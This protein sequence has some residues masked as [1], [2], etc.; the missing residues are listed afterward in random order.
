M[1]FSHSLLVAMSN[2][3]LYLKGLPWGITVPQLY[4]FVG[5]HVAE[6]PVAVYVHRND[7]MRKKCSAFVTFA[8]DVTHLVGQLNGKVYKTYWISCEVAAAKRQRFLG[9]ASL[10]CSLVFLSSV[11]AP[12]TVLLWYRNLLA[13]C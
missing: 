1:S 5:E 8:G 12:H 7:P 2:N 3:R 9:S 4:G 10:P 13:T 11:C 6:E